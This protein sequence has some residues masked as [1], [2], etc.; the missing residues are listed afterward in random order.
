MK[1]AHVYLFTDHS[2]TC[3]RYRMAFPVSSLC[4]GIFPAMKEAS[5]FSS[6]HFARR[7]AVSCA[8]NQPVIYQPTKSVP[9]PEAE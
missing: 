5:G 4:L 2:R 8:T 3:W 6:A 7:H 9:H 1:P